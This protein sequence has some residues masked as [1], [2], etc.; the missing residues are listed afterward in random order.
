MLTVSLRWTSHLHKEP[1]SRPTRTCILMSWRATRLT[2][3]RNRG[4]GRKL[5]SRAVYIWVDSEIRANCG[6]D[7]GEACSW[8][9]ARAKKKQ[10]CKKEH[11][12]G[13]GAA[14]CARKRTRGRSW[15]AQR[16][17]VPP[18]H[19]GTPACAR[20]EDRQG[21]DGA[22]ASRRTRGR[23]GL[24]RPYGTPTG[25][26]PV[27]Q[28]LSRDARAHGLYRQPTGRTDSPSEAALARD[29]GPRGSSPAFRDAGFHAL[30]KQAQRQ[31]DSRQRLISRVTSPSNCLPLAPYKRLSWVP[32][33]RRKASVSKGGC[34][35]SRPCLRAMSSKSPLICSANRPSPRIRVPK[36]GSLS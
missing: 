24:P 23:P 19:P 34:G 25:R 31:P 36:R 9:G 28:Q 2:A 30:G 35:R 13:D 18:V 14:A 17:A 5:R 8:P 1:G 3:T 29:L 15:T 22:Y 20:R 11:T 32:P 33:G 12:D 16:L 27:H 4:L 7:C 21:E 6:F 10:S 26:H